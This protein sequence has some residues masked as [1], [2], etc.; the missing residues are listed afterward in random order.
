MMNQQG[1]THRCAPYWHMDCLG[2]VAILALAFN[3]RQR[4]RLSGR[5]GITVD[6]DSADPV[7]IYCDLHEACHCHQPLVKAIGKELDSRFGEVMRK[8]SSADLETIGR[9][10]TPFPL[11]MLWATLSDSREEVRLEGRRRL[12]EML[13]QAFRLSRTV[14]EKQE[15]SADLTR[16]LSQE[17]AG[18]KAR[19]GDLERELKHA[20]RTLET[21]RPARVAATRPALPEA[22]V[23][24]GIV[25]RLEREVRKLTHELNRERERTAWLETE[26]YALQSREGG[27]STPG[28]GTAAVAEATGATLI[29]GFEIQPF[30]ASARRN[31]IVCKGDMLCPDR[32]GCTR[33]CPLKDLTVAI[34]GGSEG[35]LPAYLGMVGELGG[36]CLYHNGCLRQ[37]AD[38][39][40]RIIG[41]ADI[42][43]C[44]TSVNSHAAVQF[45]K[46]M[47][48]R[49]G[50]RLLVTRESGVHSLKEMLRQSAN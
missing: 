26:L 33:D 38:R 16:A 32:D 37:G 34:L 10:E 4:K 30:G 14:R 1:E 15:D 50:K 29:E 27:Q 41:Q 5:Y 3:R 31:T 22:A 36:E 43:V 13:L 21:A 49:S 28:F 11:P 24:P 18:L 7:T 47:C 19:I 35:A 44:I 2:T 45:A 9:M 40:K 42:V 12:H 48:K 39:L 46:A 20:H 25:A 23:S 6:A 8:V 17:N